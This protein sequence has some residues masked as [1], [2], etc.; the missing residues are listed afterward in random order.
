MLKLHYIYLRHAPIVAARRHDYQTHNNPPE[1]IVKAALKPQ[2]NTLS[3]DKYTRSKMITTVLSFRGVAAGWQRTLA[4]TILK[5]KL[6][7]SLNIVDWCPTGVKVAMHAVP[8]MKPVPESCIA[9]SPIN[10]TMIINGTVT[11]QR[12]LQIINAQFSRLYERRC[13]VHWF[14]GEGMEEGEFM[15]ASE[16]VNEVIDHYKNAEMV[17]D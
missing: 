15:E 8:P 16:A 7:Q 14:V 12:A 2:F 9:E 17:E 10:L 5:S 3:T 1:D 13:F 4:S 11:T 6:N